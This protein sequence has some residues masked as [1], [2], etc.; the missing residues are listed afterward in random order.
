[1][2]TPKTRAANAPIGKRKIAAQK[3]DVITHINHYLTVEMLP[4]SIC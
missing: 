1:M 3:G 4:S 2:S